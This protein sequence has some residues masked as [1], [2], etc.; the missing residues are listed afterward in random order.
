MT[1]FTQRF[2]RLLSVLLLSVGL[3][4]SGCDTTSNAVEDDAAPSVESE[5]MSDAVTS[6][7][8]TAALS[9]EQTQTLQ[10]LVDN[11]KDMERQPGQLWFL[12]ADVHAE[13]TSEQIQK[14]KTQLQERRDSVREDGNRPGRDGPKEHVRKRV[15]HALKGLDL[16]EAQKDELR[17]IRAEYRD[18]LMTLRGA[19]RDGS[20]DEADA[21]RWRTLRS[22]M[23]EAVREVLTEEQREQ[24]EARR[25]ERNARRDS[26]REARREALGLTDEQIA[27]FEELRSER[28][29]ERRGPRRGPR[30][31]GTP[32]DS[33]V[34]S[35][36]TQ[37]QREIVM[38]H[39]VL[40]HGAMT[41]HKE[42]RG[43]RS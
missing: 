38:I 2:P 15:R 14:I 28:T 39:R 7:S 40:R 10:A 24:M 32:G 34:A 37:E 8:K 12:A 5:A 4:L 43:P 21:E 17:S 41:G 35:I 23:R 3:L 31:R 6:V 18:E 16:T 22:E 27:Q 29:G 33:P 20:F 25:E 11:Y 30:H 36:L 19:R 9:D 26:V 1:F 13:L 42:R